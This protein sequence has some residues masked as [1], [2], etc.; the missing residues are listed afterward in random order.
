M[1]KQYYYKKFTLALHK[2]VKTAKNVSPVYK[3]GIHYWKSDR[4]Y[5]FSIVFPFCFRFI[6][7]KEIKFPCVCHEMPTKKRKRNS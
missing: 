1:Y 6:L 7:S 2:F 3:I 5:N 4:W